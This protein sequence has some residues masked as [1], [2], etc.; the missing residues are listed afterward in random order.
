MNYIQSIWEVLF[1]WW[2]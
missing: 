1:R 2:W